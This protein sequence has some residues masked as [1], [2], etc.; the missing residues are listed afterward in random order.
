MISHEKKV[1][2]VHIRK[3]GGTTIKNLFPDYDPN[4]ALSGALS[5]G[6]LDSGWFTSPYVERYFKFAVVRNPWDRFI[7]GY[8]YC[9]STRKR[10]LLDVL[11][12]LPRER[13]AM[14]N[15]L[16]TGISLR[17]RMGYAGEYTRKFCRNCLIGV[18]RLEGDIG[19]RS[20][21]YVH[22]V[23]MQSDYI[24]DNDGRSAVDL[25]ARLEDLDSGINELSSKV[26]PLA[27]HNGVF[28]NKNRNRKKSYRDYFDS[29][30]LKI[31]EKKFER[32]IE[33]L[34]YTY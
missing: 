32:D 20:E 7:S 19:W 23:R 33:L 30:S 9:R 2:F 14:S 22:L 17:S 21:D 26:G 31:F 6:L 29:E 13:V 15:A 8:L 10:P 34:G 27:R 12:N 18:G 28:M 4:S 11:K 3:S 1:I 24:F 5:D 16:S 25:I